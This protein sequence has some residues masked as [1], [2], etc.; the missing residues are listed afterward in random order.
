[1]FCIDIDIIYRI[2]YNILMFT[3]KS[4]YNIVS[5]YLREL[6]SR[7]E[8]SAGSRSSPTYYATNELVRIVQIIFVSVYL[9][10]LLH[11]NG[12]NISEH[13][14]LILSGRVLNNM[15]AH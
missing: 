12:V 4:Y 6:S 1:M 2:T 9:F 14:I 15:D 13:Q 8:S 5:T 10:M 11:A 7:K 3:S